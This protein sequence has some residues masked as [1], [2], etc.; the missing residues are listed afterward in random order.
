MK[1]VLLV[2][3]D[4]SITELLHSIATTLGMRCD[5]LDST[6]RAFTAVMLSPPDIAVVDILY[7]DKHAIPFIRFCT[8]NYP[9]TKLILTSTWW[10]KNIDTVLSDISRTIL[11]SKPFKLEEIEQN[12]L[13]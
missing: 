13:N 7:A 9:N 10:P 2:E 11:L 5:H 12:L 1:S 3:S 6:E 8:E 4:P